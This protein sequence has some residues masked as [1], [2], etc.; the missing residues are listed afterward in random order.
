MSTPTPAS[1][2]TTNVP[3]M[4]QNPLTLIMTIKSPQDY[5]ELNA[6][7]QKFATMPPDQNPIYNALNSIR[8]VHF[9]RFVFL[10]NNTK[11]AIITAYDG[12]LETYLKDFAA[13]IG[14]IF[15][16]LFKYMVDPPPSPVQQHPD[17]YLAYVKANNAPV[18]SFYSAYPNSTV[19]DILANQ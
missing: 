10:E 18:V 14:D 4:V 7:L 2:T 11:L 17:E 6:V 1:P 15:D 8:T 19:L 16:L 3:P 5:Q 12:D 9:A 13:K